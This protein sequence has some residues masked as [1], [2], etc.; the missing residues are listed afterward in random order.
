MQRDRPPDGLPHE[1]IGEF[2]VAVAEDRAKAAQLLTQH[3]ALLNARWMHDETVLH[4][5]AIEGYTEGV[6][7]LIDRGAD[8]NA[9]NEFG[10]S[11][12]VDVAS[13]GN[14]E[15]AEI[16]LKHGADPNA[17]SEVRDNAM[18]A[19][20]GSGNARLVELLLKAGA[21]ARYRTSLGETVF[22]VYIQRPEKREAVL[23]KL[24]EYGITPDSI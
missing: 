10:D 2:I 5:L 1:L 11:V 18:H 15:V 3:P 12:L 6:Q 17:A 14:D 21:N 16:L 22:D 19:A 4:F 20:A 8:V 9:I 23:A 13:L 7:F 24:A